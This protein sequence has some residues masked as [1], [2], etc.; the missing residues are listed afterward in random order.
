MYCVKCRKATDTS[1]VEFT[2]SKNGRNMKRAKCVM[3]GTT[4]IPVLN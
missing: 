3:C 4:K 2:V 1:N